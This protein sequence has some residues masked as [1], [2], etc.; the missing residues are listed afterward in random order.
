MEAP[1][2][3]LN[4]VSHPLINTV[5]AALL[6]IQLGIAGLCA[7]NFSLHMIDHT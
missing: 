6:E 3:P 1:N 5:H 4:T 2:G 7:P